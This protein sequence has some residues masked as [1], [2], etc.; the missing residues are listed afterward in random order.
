M[1][2]LDFFPERITLK[3]LRE[4]ADGCQGC[5][6]YKKATQTVFGEGPRDAKLIMV[7]EV[8]GDQEDRQ[9]KPFVGPAGRLLQEALVEAGIQREEVYITNAVKHFSFEERGKRRLHK[10]PTARQISAC[11][12]WLEAEIGQIKPAGIV[13]LGA[14]AAQALLGRA[15]RITQ[16]RGQFLSSEWADWIMA[17][18]HPS[19]L[20][21]A[22]DEAARAEMK[23]VFLA[24]MRAA[25]KRL[26][27]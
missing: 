19:A 27:G 5:D 3:S 20:L 21:R 9:G 10:K 15:F 24:D 17:T 13:C 2:A 16:Q 7:G 11:R 23:E 1:S 12:P 8:P 25:A 26:G 18:Y 4:A 14:T 6:L 22:P